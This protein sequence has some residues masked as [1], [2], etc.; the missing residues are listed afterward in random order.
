MPTNQ[1]KQQIPEC[2]YNCPYDPAKDE[3]QEVEEPISECEIA[4]EVQS[5]NE[6]PEEA[7]T[8]ILRTSDYEGDVHVDTLWETNFGPKVGI[9]SQ[10]EYAEVF[11]ELDWEKAHHKWNSER[12]TDTEMWEVDLD[13]LMYVCFFFLN[14][15]VDVTIDDDIREQYIRSQEGKS[16]NVD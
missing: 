14:E 13:A 2:P 16:V 7:M 11:N 4:K 9:K 1:E 3:R 5:G 6:S 15:G 12:V 10:P 8:A